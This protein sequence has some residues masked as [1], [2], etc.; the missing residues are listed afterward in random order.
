VETGPYCDGAVALAHRDSL[1]QDELNSADY[2]EG[3][4]MSAVA[5]L[6]MAMTDPDHI[7]MEFDNAFTP[8]DLLVARPSSLG[9]RYRYLKEKQPLQFG[10]GQRWLPLLE[11]LIFDSFEEKGLSSAGSHDNQRLGNVDATSTVASE[12]EWLIRSDE[13]RWLDSI[14]QLFRQNGWK[15]NLPT[16]IV[17][18]E[19]V[20]DE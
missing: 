5:E 8:F 16:N 7:L 1:V 13:R 11:S 9:I 12:Q 15:I 10:A 17:Q 4:S 3:L 14:L 6:A 19:K 20:Y 18:L 2:L